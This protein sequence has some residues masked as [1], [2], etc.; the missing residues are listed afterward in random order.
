VGASRGA[1]ACFASLNRRAVCFFQL[2]ISL[3]ERK[4]ARTNQKLSYSSRFQ[5]V[6]ITLPLGMRML[7]FASNLGAYL[8]RIPID[9]IGPLGL[10]PPLAACHRRIYHGS[11]L[12][13][14]AGLLPLP[15]SDWNRSECQADCRTWTAARLGASWLRGRVSSL[16]SP[17][18]AL[19]KSISYA[20]ELHV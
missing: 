19:C 12:Y 11:A 6:E 10:S 2:S 20:D 7:N 17:R 14:S 16:R 13:D 15:V 18:R 8:N 5:A 1:P 4:N 9:L 3:R